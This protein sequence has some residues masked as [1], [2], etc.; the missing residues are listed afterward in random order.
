MATKFSDLFFAFS[1]NARARARFICTTY[2]ASNVNVVTRHYFNF[3]FFSLD[4]FAVHSP[5]R[6]RASNRFC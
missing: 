6:S 4:I 3:Y 5:S 1:A 2:L